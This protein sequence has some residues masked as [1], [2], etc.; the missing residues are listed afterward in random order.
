MTKKTKCDNY[1][2]NKHFTCYR[3]D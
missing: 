2:Q 3:Y 1:I